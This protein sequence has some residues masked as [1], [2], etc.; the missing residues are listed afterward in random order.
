MPFKASVGEYL[1][2]DVTKGIESMIYGLSQGMSDPVYFHKVRIF[3]EADWIIDVTAGFARKL[4][5]AGILGRNGFFDH[6]KVH[7]DQSAVPPIVE[8]EKIERVQ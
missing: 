7:F 8:I 3:V 6:F 4:A 2:M 5:V 1:G